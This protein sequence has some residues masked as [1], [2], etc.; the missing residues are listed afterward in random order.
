MPARHVHLVRHGLPLV[1]PDAAASSW[2]LDPAGV[3]SISALRASG[4]LPDRAAWFSSP[5]PKAR[6]TA[7]TLTDQPVEV[8][9]ALRE[10]VRLH[11]G[12]IPDF[13]AVLA[14]AFARP[15]RSAYDGWE[16]LDATGRR[17]SAAVR[18]LLRRHPTG[19]LVLVGHGT[20]LALVAA[21]L[22]GTPVNP[23]APAAMGFPDVVTVRMSSPADVRPLSLR[24]VMALSVALTVGELVAWQ[25]ADRV[26]WVLGPAGV[27]SAM[28]S[29]PRRTRDL[30][31]SLLAAVLIAVF[32]ATG[33]L[34][35]MPRLRA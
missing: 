7:A 21:D 29:V 32:L 5:E 24:V 26:G 27:V 23:F 16:P 33:L 19:D 35:G 13:D 17:I 8:I 6:E 34:L 31:V 3:G 12:W 2:T 20:S 18:D 4:R 28:A 11:V 10:Q 15:E 9:D 22:T 30:G 25:G 1:D 14:E